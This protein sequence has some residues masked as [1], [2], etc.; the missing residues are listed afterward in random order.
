MS[1]LNEWPLIGKLLCCCSQILCVW[2]SL[3]TVWY[4]WLLQQFFIDLRKNT[5]VASFKPIQ[6][7]LCFLVYVLATTVASICRSLKKLKNEGS[8][9]FRG[10]VAQKLEKKTFSIKILIIIWKICLRQ[11][12]MNGND[13]IVFHILKK[14]YS[15]LSI[16][17]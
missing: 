7:Y 3:T 13:I 8:T 16:K 17:R 9:M 2:P 10:S 6:P 12:K 11:Q 1:D 14:N 5:S 4:F 15:K